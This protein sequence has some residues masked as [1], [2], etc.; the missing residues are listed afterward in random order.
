MPRGENAQQCQQKVSGLLT[1][2]CTFYV[3]GVGG[4]CV[5][6]CVELFA[7]KANL[8]LKFEIERLKFRKNTFQEGAEQISARN[9]GSKGWFML[10]VGALLKRMLNFSALSE[11]V[12]PHKLEEFSSR[13]QLK[14]C[15]RNFLNIKIIL[16]SFTYSE[17]SRRYIRGYLAFLNLVRG[18]LFL[19]VP[20]YCGKASLNI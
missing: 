14:L 6:T 11:D 8:R 16:N 9:H 19:S 20:R 7:Q 17:D 4:G 1:R 10:S 15:S 12:S 13:V 18:W 5:T 3:L 2:N